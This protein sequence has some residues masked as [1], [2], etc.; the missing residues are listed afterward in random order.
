MASQ[1]R[2]WSSRGRV[3][4]AARPLIVG[5]PASL[6]PRHSL[7][8]WSGSR[9]S[10][11]SGSF[12]MCV[13]LPTRA[14]PRELG[15]SSPG[16]HCS[17]AGN[18]LEVEGTPSTTCSSTYGAGSGGD[19]EG[20]ACEAEL[21]GREAVLHASPSEAD[22]MTTHSEPATVIDT[23]FGHRSDGRSATF[24]LASCRARQG[25]AP[26]VPVSALRSGPRVAANRSR[27]NRCQWTVLAARRTRTF[28]RFFVTSRAPAEKRSRP[29]SQRAGGPHR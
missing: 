25:L 2:N 4:A 1:T 5:N 22:A 16:E 13:F 23:V 24:G 8:G 12:S 7:R 15:P 29:L 11:W 14:S 21:L 6:R 19:D 10:L 27:T 3:V 17:A 18:A 20:S 28:V 9:S 26:G